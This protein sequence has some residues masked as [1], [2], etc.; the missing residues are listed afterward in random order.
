MALLQCHKT[1][2][3]YL[4]FLGDAAYWN[5]VAN[6][7]E[8][9]TKSNV[10]RLLGDVYAE[11]QLAKGLT[12]KT[13]FGLDIANKRDYNYTTSKITTSTGY[14]KGGNGYT[15]KMSRLTEN[16]LS[17][18]N[19]WGDHRFTATGVYSWQNYMYETLSI[20]GNGFANDETV[21]GYGT[22]QIGKQSSMEVINM[23]I[24]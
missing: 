11:F 1:I 20:S 15:K 14:G 9:T 16:I 22:S 21:H 12:F 19:E 3:G 10:S 5:P 13:N 4:L 7:K 2:Q 23:K 18:M 24:R 17:Y 6:Y 8:V